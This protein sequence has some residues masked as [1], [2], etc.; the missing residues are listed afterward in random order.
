MASERMTAGP[1]ELVAILRGDSHVASRYH[2]E[3]AN[4]I[5]ALTKEGDQL[6]DVVERQGRTLKRALEN[7]REVWLPLLEA[8][9]RF[10]KDFAEHFGSE[11]QGRMADAIAK[12]REVDV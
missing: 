1:L 6:A 10:Y 11:S 3:A 2:R 8:A 7:E 5:E 12:A 9:E 4:E